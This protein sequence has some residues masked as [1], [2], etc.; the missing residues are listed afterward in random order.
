MSTILNAVYMG[1]YY[2]FVPVITLV[3]LSSIVVYIKSFKS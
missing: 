2:L 1:F 3:I